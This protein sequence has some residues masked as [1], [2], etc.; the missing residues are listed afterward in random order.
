MSVTYTTL[1]DAIRLAFEAKGVSFNSTNPAPSQKLSKKA[2]GGSGSKVVAELRRLLV[3]H[4]GKSEHGSS[5]TVGSFVFALKPSTATSEVN[6][7]SIAALCELG[8]RVVVELDGKL[9]VRALVE[10]V[11]ISPTYVAFTVKLTFGSVVASED[12][13]DLLMGRV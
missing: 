7:D 12:T 6:L 5:A 3:T 9:E 11:E 13:D 2:T 8:N 4:N 1:L 10:T